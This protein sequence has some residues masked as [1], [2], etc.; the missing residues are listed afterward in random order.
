[1]GQWLVRPPEPPLGR[2]FDVGDGWLWY[3]QRDL[4]ESDLVRFNW[5]AEVD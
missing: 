4:D 1:V 3:G 2:P 5:P